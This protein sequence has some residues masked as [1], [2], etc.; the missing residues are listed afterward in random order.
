MSHVEIEVG[1]GKEIATVPTLEDRSRDSTS[2][3]DAPEVLTNARL[4]LV[5][6]AAAITWFQGVSHPVRKLVKLD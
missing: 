1:D 2:Q 5:G 3:T 4:A 6:L